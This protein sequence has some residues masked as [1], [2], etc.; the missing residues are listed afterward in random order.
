MLDGVV[1]RAAGDGSV[2]AVP[3]DETI[4]FSN[5]TFFDKDET[6]AIASAD[7]INDIKSLTAMLDEKVASLGENRFYVI[8]IDGKFD[9]MNVRSELAQSEPYK[10][11][12]EV[13]ETDQTFFDYENIEGTVVGLY[14]PPYM[15]SLANEWKRTASPLVL[16]SPVRIVPFPLSNTVLYVPDLT[17]PL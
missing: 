15:S 1:Y 17:R 10:P 6:Q 2:E 12:A 13:L 3:D 14:C 4:P 5:V 8:R 7:E 11:L 16:I 9:K